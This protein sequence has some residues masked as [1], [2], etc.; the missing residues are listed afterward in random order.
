MSPSSAIE[1][2]RFDAGFREKLTQLFAWRRDV[3]RFKPDP[4]DAAI[5]DDLIA[6]AALAPSV[7]LSEPWRL[8]KVDDR[9]RRAAIAAE[10]ERAN[11]EALA[12]Y[13]GERAAHY[14]RLKLSGLREAPIH[15]AM[16]AEEAPAQGG[17]LGRRTM[18]E[19]VRYSAVTAV[20][21]FWLAARAR[22]IGVGWVSILDPRRVAD[23]LETPGDWALVAYLCVGWPVEEHDDPE[24]HRH[25]WER[26]RAAIPVLQR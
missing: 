7:G 10:F 2:P 25:G 5:L 22:G 19:T 3:R 17:G 4:V 8:V 1:P 13:E 6:Q 18:P 16:F 20:Y 26:R 9:G 24:L 23:I 12:E 21:T 14:A 15:L 11:A